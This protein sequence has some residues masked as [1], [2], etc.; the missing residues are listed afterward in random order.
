[1]GRAGFWKHGGCIRAR[2]QSSVRRSSAS[3]VRPSL[4][5]PPPSPPPSLSV[6]KPGTVSSCFTLPVGTL[7]RG[8]V[9]P[10]SSLTCPV[11]LYEVLS[12]LVNVGAALTLS[13]VWSCWHRFSHPPSSFTSLA[14]S[15]FSYF[16]LPSFSP[17]LLLPAT[18]SHA[19]PNSS[20]LPTLTGARTSGPPSPA[21][22][23][24]Q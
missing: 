24:P 4:P 19:S 22:A 5:S 20:T 7:A 18:P 3:A 21:T 8:M 16:C 17:S 6:T 23:P 13:G 12:L 2:S 11:P 14:L 15:L 10:L 1:M 9:A